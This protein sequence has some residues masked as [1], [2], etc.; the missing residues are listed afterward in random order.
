MKTP[1]PVLDRRR[2]I[3]VAEKLPFRIGHRDYE[4]EA[5]T[6]N[7]SC[8]GALCIVDLDIPLMT[9]LQVALSL[10]PLRKGASHAKTIPIKGVVVRKDKD[11]AGRQFLIAIYFSEIRPSDREF[12]EKFIESRLPA[13]AQ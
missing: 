11:A 3:R 10:P 6:I 9:Q 8:Q 13:D 5:R 12:L 2:S 4:T 1:K 7:I